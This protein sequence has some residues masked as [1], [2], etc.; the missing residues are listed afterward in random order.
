[1]VVSSLQVGKTPGPD[2]FPVE[3][4]KHYTEDPLPTYHLVLLRALEE[5]SLPPS[6]SETVV[7]VLHKPG[8]DP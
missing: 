1:M 8:K 3:F 2:G 5:C 6:M 4:F 7:V